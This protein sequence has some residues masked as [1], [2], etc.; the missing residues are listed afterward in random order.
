MSERLA[1]VRLRRPA[2]LADWGEARRLVEEY[3]AS[4]GVDLSFQNVADEL[5][6]LPTEYGPPGGDFLLADR[7]GSTVGCAGLRHFGPSVGEM[8]RLYVTPAGRGRGVGRI[9]AERIVIRAR[10]LGYARLVLDTLPLMAE[11][12]ALYRSMGFRPIEPYRFNPVAGTA[13]LG[14][15]LG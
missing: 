10:E 1:I 11:A 9:L 7:E 2:T 5:G 12:R 3:V 15:D 8:K 14:L 4:L 6:K 13:F